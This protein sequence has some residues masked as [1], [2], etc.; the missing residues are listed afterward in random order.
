MISVEQTRSGGI[1]A[2]VSGPFTS[3]DLKA[4]G[5]QSSVCLFLEDS[6]GW[7][8]S[9]LENVARL[10][11]ALAGLVVS[12]ER[13]LDASCLSSVSGLE[14]MALHGDIRGEVGLSLSPELYGLGLYVRGD[15]LKIA[16]VPG[17]LKVFAGSVRQGVY[18][19]VVGATRLEAMTLVN[20]SVHS[21][22]GE[23]LFSDIKYVQIHRSPKVIDVGQVIRGG[24]EMFKANSCRR[25]RVNRLDR[26]GQNIRYFAMNDCDYI[27]SLDVF[28]SARNLS[29][30]SIGGGTR[31]L[32][33]GS[34]ES[35]RQNKLRKVQSEGGARLEYLGEL[36]TDYASS[37]LECVRELE[38]RASI[39][40]NVSVSTS[41]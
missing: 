15:H 19:A 1:R 8:G 22:G 4:L 18:D 26:C 36:L 32:D 2:D 21:L 39:F 7:D 37:E 16:D 41:S 5:D 31:L 24:I 38:T 10:G 33:G 27:E 12:S 40:R 17:S 34:A 3:D 28:H 6:T 14:S 35:A 9:G 20:A 11:G 25:L 23:E 30:V 29:V 13:P